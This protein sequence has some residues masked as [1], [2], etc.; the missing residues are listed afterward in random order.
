MKIEELLL[1]NSDS[2]RCTLCDSTLK[3]SVWRGVCLALVYKDNILTK[4][5][6]QL[7][8]YYCVNCMVKNDRLSKKRH[9]RSEKE[10]DFFVDTLFSQKLRA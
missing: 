7:V 6:H 2:K 8:E 5:R 9:K 3:G 4:T 1:I 10:L